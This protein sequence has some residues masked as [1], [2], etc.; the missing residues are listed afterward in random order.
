MIKLKGTRTRLVS[1]DHL[2]SVKPALTHKS[3]IT[4]V[5][6]YTG[7]IGSFSFTSA[8]EEAIMQPMERLPSPLL[9]RQHTS[10]HQEMVKEPATCRADTKTD[11][12]D[13]WAAAEDAERERRVLKKAPRRQERRRTQTKMPEE[14]SHC[15]ATA[16]SGR[17]SKWVHR[18]RKS[19][20]TALLRDVAPEDEGLDITE[21]LQL[22]ETY[23]EPRQRRSNPDQAPQASIEERLLSS[24]QPEMP[25]AGHKPARMDPVWQFLG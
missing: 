16:P 11:L 15:A 6:S 1:N 14:P 10:A 23:L 12:Y 21:M 22:E 4:S 8:E 25:A 7:S 3:S 5:H 13:L 20:S 17:V 19:T 24:E 2:K 18:I 9:E